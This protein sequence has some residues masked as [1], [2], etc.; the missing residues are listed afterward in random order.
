MNV[1]ALVGVSEVGVN[2]AADQ[3]AED[4][5]VQID[6]GGEFSCLAGVQVQLDVEVAMPTAA[7]L[8]IVLVGTLC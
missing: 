1:I 4:I 2:F 7:Q 3:I 5:G 8:T 6:A